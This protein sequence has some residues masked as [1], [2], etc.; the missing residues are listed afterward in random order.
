MFD[1][2]SLLKF[3]TYWVCDNRSYAGCL[4]F[5][6]AVG[7]CADFVSV[8]FRRKFRQV[9]VFQISADSLA[10]GLQLRQVVVTVLMDRNRRIFNAH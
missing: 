7:W 9:R 3:A 5:A 8:R 1:E 4:P 10:H 6:I 2:K